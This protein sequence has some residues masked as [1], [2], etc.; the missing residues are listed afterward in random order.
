MGAV[1]ILSR[2]LHNS[3]KFVLRWGG[4]SFNVDLNGN[5]QMA[6]FESSFCLFKHLALGIKEVLSRQTDWT[7]GVIV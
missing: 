6:I 4:E 2:A 7:L 5:E 3:R 1:S